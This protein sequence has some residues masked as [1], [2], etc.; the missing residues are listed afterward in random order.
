MKV[1]AR[2]GLP[3]MEEREIMSGIFA[4]VGTGETH[5]K[6]IGDDVTK[7][8]MQG[9]PYFQSDEDIESLIA[10]GALG[11]ASDLPEEEDPNA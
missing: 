7:A 5:Y 6:E 11:S 2:I 8:E 10:D 4:K 1:L 9:E 3:V